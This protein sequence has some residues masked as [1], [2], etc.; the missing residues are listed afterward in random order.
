MKYI[1]QEVI[2]DFFEKITESKIPYVLIKNVSN[3]L[4]D[5]LMDG[6]DID[7]LVHE[8]HIED[9]EQFMI[10]NNFEK[11][12]H[13]LGRKNGW[14][15]AYKLPEYQF[16]KLKNEQFTLYIDASFKLSCKSLT[17]NIWIPLDHC[18]NEDIWIN[19]IFDEKNHWWIMDDGTILIY[20]IVR[21]IFDKREFK[22]GYVDGI[23]ERKELLK[24]KGVQYKL[25]K[26]F[27]HYTGPLIEQI[28]KSQYDSI[29]ENYLTFTEY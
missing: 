22:Q 19:K 7:I 6:K 12:I 20:L 27:F 9:F 15:F 24:E 29:I 1:P 4:P 3:E 23:E 2:G 16:W 10:Q 18:I 21:S 26:I 13:P 5:Q 17:P 28:S 11:Q 14:N 8:E 25:S